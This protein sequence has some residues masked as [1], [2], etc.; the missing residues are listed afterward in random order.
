MHFRIRIPS[1]VKSIGKHCFSRCLKLKKVL[2]SNNSQ[3]KIIGED[4]FS[5]TSIESITIPKHVS[6]IK[7]EA[8]YQSDQLKKVEFS[9]DSEL[10]I[11]EESPFSDCNLESIK[12]PVHVKEIGD[13]CI[14]NSLKIQNLKN[15]VHLI[16][17][18]FFIFIYGIL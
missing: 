15:L 7:K 16:L 4:S 18:I 13:A 9:D 2:I 11:F 1:S 12:I 10:L 17:R 3:L 6:I 5:K 8:F 14:D